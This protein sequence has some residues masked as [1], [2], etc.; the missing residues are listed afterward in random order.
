MTLTLIKKGF[1]IT[2]NAR[3]DVFPGGFVV[4]EGTRI[5]RVGAGR[6]VPDG[7]FDRVID[8]EG[9]IVVPGLINAHQ[10]FYYHL[11][12]GLANGLLLEDWFPQLV[13]RVGPHLTADDIELTAYADLTYHLAYLAQKQGFCRIIASRD[14][15]LPDSQTAMIAARNELF[16]SRRDAL[17]RFV[18]AYIHAG[19]IFNKVAGEPASHPDMLN[20]IVKYIFVKDTEI[21]KAVAPHWEWIA[22]DGVPNAA[23]VMEQQNYWA[24]TFKLVERKVSQEALF[25]LA[26]ACEATKR[27]E[28]EKPFGT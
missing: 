10:H 14:E 13:A 18:M 6:D 20:V 12:K 23:S 21:L 25:D 26:I 15:I 3:R 5:A 1:V 8:A 17:V 2:M 4:I 7:A 11:F 28:R 24:D 22:E 19:R 9:M 27:L 16:Q